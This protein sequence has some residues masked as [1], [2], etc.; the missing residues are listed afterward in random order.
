MPHTWYNVGI[1]RVVD[2]TT[3][4]ETGPFR[5]LLLTTDDDGTDT[6][7]R[8]RATVG[9]IIGSAAVEASVANYSRQTLANHARLATDGTA[10]RIEWQ[11]NDVTW[12]DLGTDESIVAAVLYEGTLDSGDD[13]TNIPILKITAGFPASCN[14]EDFH[15][16]WNGSTDGTD[17]II[18][19]MRHPS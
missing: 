14:G 2:H 1:Q 7:Q 8:S 16:R 19:V 13:A 10:D 9:A 6:V 12:S 5:L 15:L 4:L 3:D 11:G 18:A 17:G